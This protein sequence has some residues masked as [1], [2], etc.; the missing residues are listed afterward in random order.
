MLAVNAWGMRGNHETVDQLI[1]A[2]RIATDNLKNFLERGDNAVVEKYDPPQNS[3][4]LSPIQER[5]LEESGVSII[6]A[7]NE[8]ETTIKDMKNIKPHKDAYLK[9]ESPKKENSSFLEN[10]ELVERQVIYKEDFNFNIPFN[11]NQTAAQK[12]RYEK[13]QKKPL[14]K[15]EISIADSLDEMNRRNKKNKKKE[16]LDEYFS[17]QHPKNTSSNNTQNVEKPTVKNG[18]SLEERKKLLSDL[19]NKTGVGAK[20]KASSSRPL[21]VFV[22][23][24]KKAV[25]NKPEEVSNIRKPQSKKTNPILEERRKF[26]KEKKEKENKIKE[27]KIK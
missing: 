22:N 6:D 3:Q 11:D 23:Q 2:V 10:V 8:L 5:S 18:L 13:Y 25:V 26:E 20:K 17:N 7:L 19:K 1:A 15:S 21:N 14:K 4:H 16:R 12:Q 9:Q 24:P 27:N